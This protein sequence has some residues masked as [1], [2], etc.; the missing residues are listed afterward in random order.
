M[1]SNSEKNK[2]TENQEL[3]FLQLISLTSQTCLVTRTWQNLSMIYQ[4]NLLGT[5]NMLFVV[6]SGL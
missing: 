4:N 1:Y 3:Y 5:T 2:N 6:I